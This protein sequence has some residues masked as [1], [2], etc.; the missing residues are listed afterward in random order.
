MRGGFAKAVAAAAMGAAL[1]VPLAGQAQAAPAR[2][3][4]AHHTT[5]TCAPWVKH[6]RGATA[7]CKDGTFSFSAHFSGTCSHHRGV[8]YWFK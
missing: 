2:S 4:C 6:P 5:G 7:K 1:L 8:R 3:A